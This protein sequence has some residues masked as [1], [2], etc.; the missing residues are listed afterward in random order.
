MNE[1]RSL[2]GEE[3]L[4]ALYNL[5]MYAFHASPPFPDKEEWADIV[6]QRRGVT[7][8]ALFEDGTAAA[9]AAS[10]AMTQNVRGKL[11]PASAVWGV[12]TRPA[13]RRNGYCTQTMASLLRAESAAGKVFSALYPF[14]ES[15]YQRQGYV[16]FPL[17][18]IARLSPLSLAPLVG[19]NTGG[20]VDLKMSGEAFEGYREFLARMRRGMHGMGFFDVGDKHVADRNRLWMAFA[21][22]DGEVEGMMVYTLQGEEVSKFNLCA[23]RFYYTTSRGRYLLLDWIARH[24][25]QADRVE[26][27]LSPMEHPETWLEDIQVRV[28]SQVRAPMGRVLNVAGTGGMDA[29]AGSFR[30]HITDRLCPF[31]EG[32]W[33]FKSVDGRLQVT[34][35]DGADCEFSIQGLAALMFGTHDPADFAWRGWGNPPQ[36]VQ[37]VM[38]G[39]FPPKLPFLHENF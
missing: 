9:G 33:L 18:A 28:E 7:Y 26:I 11:Y 8:H 12:A 16:T 37:D 29:E 27:W 20:E 21:R 22:F 4:D 34:K 14:R 10:T 13:A 23:Y 17:P 25:D 39:M 32:D 38:R 30:A 24:T 36:E 31:N 5:N 3:M 15:F 19:R 1:I 6:R 35:T 2:Q